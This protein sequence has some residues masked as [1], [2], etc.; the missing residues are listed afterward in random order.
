MWPYPLETAD[1][2]TFTEQIPYTKLHFLCTVLAR[3][4]S[5]DIPVQIQQQKH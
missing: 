1:I 5:K 2:V 4:P 3:F